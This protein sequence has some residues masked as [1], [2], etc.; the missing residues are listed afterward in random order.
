M[1]QAVKDFVSLYG[2]NSMNYE[3]DS[4]VVTDFD[5]TS[6]IFDIQD[7]CLIYQLETMA[8][9]LNPDE[10]GIVLRTNLDGNFDDV[11]TDIVNAYA[12]LYENYGPFDSKGLDDDHAKAIAQEPHWMEFASKMCRMEDLAATYVDNW[13]IQWLAGMTAQEIYDLTYRSCRRY[14]SVETYSRTFAGPE[15]MESLSGPM[16]KTVLNGLTVD[17]MTRWLWKTLMDNGFDVWVCSASEV[18]QVRAAIDCFGL[19]DLCT[20]VTGKTMRFDEDGRLLP[21]YDFETGRGWLRDG[22][23]WRM[24]VHNTKGNCRQEG[25]I[26]TIANGIMT[27]YNGKAPLAGFMDSTG[28]FNFCTEFKRMKL[29]VCINRGDRKVTDGGSLIAEVAEYEKN[30][31]GYNLRK[32]NESGDIY[33]VLVGRDENGMRCLRESRLT[34]TFGSKEE[35][36]FANQDNHALLEYM[37]EN[38]MRVKDILERFCLKTPADSPYNPVGF[39]YGFLDEYRGYRSIE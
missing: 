35:R 32:A 1:K 26:T 33:Y 20:G 2:K 23:G 21:H 34:L 17:P 10:L 8:F 28:D 5:N 36:L 39:E 3:Q 7:Q 30:A 14:G 29:V 18:N 31:L 11:I 15:D 4:Y 6:C 13:R 24:D 12:W 19:H 27:H 37:T 38:R 25:K 16:S 22:D 9:V